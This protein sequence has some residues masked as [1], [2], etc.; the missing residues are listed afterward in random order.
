MTSATHPW[1]LLRAAAAAGL[2]LLSGAFGTPLAGA[3]VSDRHLFPAEVMT[4]QRPIASWG[5]NVKES[6]EGFSFLVGDHKFGIEEHRYYIQGSDEPP[7]TVTVL[8]YG[9]N[10]QSIDSLLRQVHI[11]PVELSFSRGAMQYPG[12]AWWLYTLVAISLI[13]PLILLRKPLRRVFTSWKQPP[14]PSVAQPG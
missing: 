10:Q 5:F 4:S 13:V 3:Q 1:S 2:L 8:Y 6:S 9:E 12:P 11:G 14:E 7:W